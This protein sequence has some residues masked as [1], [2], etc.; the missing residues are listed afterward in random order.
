MRWRTRRKGVT[1]RHHHKCRRDSHDD[2]ELVHSVELASLGRVWPPSRCCQWALSLP[3]SLA[4]RQ[5]RSS[6]RQH[7]QVEWRQKAESKESRVIARKTNKICTYKELNKNQCCDLSKPSQNGPVELIAHHLDRI[8][9]AA[10]AAL[11]N[12]CPPLL[13]FSHVNRTLPSCLSSRMASVDRR[14]SNS[15]PQS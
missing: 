15:K 12:L 6:R 5:A 11:D 13:P 4:E 10:V 1:T 8:G 2:R 7:L 3:A 14:C 9:A